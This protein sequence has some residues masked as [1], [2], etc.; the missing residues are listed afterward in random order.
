MHVY[1][2]L[3]V[4]VRLHLALRLDRDS[5]P[6]LEESTIKRRRPSDQAL[7]VPQS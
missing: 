4:P 3:L 2:C 6:S 1:V 5:F 7:G